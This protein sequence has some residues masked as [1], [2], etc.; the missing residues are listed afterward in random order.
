MGI[1]RPI[2]KV[3]L[4]VEPPHVPKFRKFRLKMLKNLVMEKN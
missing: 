1:P 3:L 2:A 4:K